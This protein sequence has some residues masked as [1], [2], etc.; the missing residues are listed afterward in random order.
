MKSVYYCYAEQDEVLC[1]ELERHLAILRRENLILEWH[2]RKIKP[3]SVYS[4]E[5]S[6]FLENADIFLLLYSADLFA[7]DKVFEAELHRALERQ[8][9]GQAVVIP[10]LIRQVSL[11]QEF[12]ASVQLP[13]NGVPVTSWENRDEAWSNVARGIRRTIT[14]IPAEIGPSSERRETS[15]ARIRIEY[16]ATFHSEDSALSETDLLGTCRPFI[17]LAWEERAP[18]QVRDVQRK[19]SP[20]RER[21]WA[22]LPWR[23]NQR[24]GHAAKTLAAV[25]LRSVEGKLSAGAALPW[26][27][28]CGPGGG[29]TTT[30][31]RALAEVAQKANQ[32]GTGNVIPVYVRLA[33]ISAA[34]S[35]QLT[36]M[37]ASAASLSQIVHTFAR[38]AERLRS[39]VEQD[40]TARLAVMLDGLDEIPQVDIRRSV[41]EWIMEGAGKFCASNS[42]ALTCRT[43]DIPASLSSSHGL[44]WHRPGRPRVQHM[45]LLPP[46]ADW[47]D[48]WIQVRCAKD[49]K[50]WR[51]LA[52]QI[53]QLRHSVLDDPRL[54]RT[55]F[56]NSP[57]LFV[58]LLQWLISERARDPDWVPTFPNHN[59]VLTR[60]IIDYSIKEAALY[61]QGSGAEQ[62]LPID[63]DEWTNIRQVVGK[64]LSQLALGQLV[65]PSDGWDLSEE[66]VVA[67]LRERTEPL[68]EH[69]RDAARLLLDKSR[70][71]PRITD[72]TRLPRRAF[73]H[74]L[75]LENLAAQELAHLIEHAT[76]APANG[77]VIQRAVSVIWSARCIPTAVRLLGPATMPKQLFKGLMACMQRSELST[78]L[79]RLVPADARTILLETLIACPENDLIMLGRAHG[80]SLSSVLMESMQN[81]RD[82]VS[83]DDLSRTLLIIEGAFQADQEMRAYVIRQRWEDIY[84]KD[85]KKFATWLRKNS[86]NTQF[87]QSLAKIW[88]LILNF[89]PSSD[90]PFDAYLSITFKCPTNGRDWPIYASNAESRVSLQKIENE[91]FKH[92][93]MTTAAIRS[94][95]SSLILWIV[96]H[97][98]FFLLAAGAIFLKEKYD[99]QPSM[100]VFDQ[101]PVPHGTGSLLLTI[102]VGTGLSV[103]P[104]VLITGM[105]GLPLRWARRRWQKLQLKVS[106]EKVWAAATDETINQADAMTWID[107]FS[108][109]PLTDQKE[110]LRRLEFLS[111]AHAEAKKRDANF[112][113]IAQLLDA[114][115]SIR[116]QFQSMR[117]QQLQGYRG[118]LTIENE[119][120]SLIDAGPGLR[121]TFRRDEFRI[122]H[123]DAASLIV[124]GG[125]G[126]GIYGHYQH[127][128]RAGLYGLI[129]GFLMLFLMG[130]RQIICS[131]RERDH[132]LSWSFWFLIIFLYATFNFGILTAALHNTEQFAMSPGNLRTDL[133]GLAIAR[134][135]LLFYDGLLVLVPFMFIITAGR[136]MLNHLLLELPRDKILKKHGRHFLMSLA[137]SSIVTLLVGTGVYV[138]GVG[139]RP[140]PY[141]ILSAHHQGIV[142]GQSTEMIIGS[143]LPV[144]QL[145]TL[146]VTSQRTPQSAQHTQGIHRALDSYLDALCQRSIWDWSA[147]RNGL[148]VEN[149]RVSFAELLG[150]L[151]RDRLL[152]KN[153]YALLACIY[154]AE[155]LTSL[156][157]QLAH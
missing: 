3:G 121:E 42:L 24:H 107:T 73:A 51:W 112:E 83:S 52:E 63:A 143:V 13:D 145:E 72:G 96:G 135:R 115:D 139:G 61:V 148:S 60:L 81:Q 2:K 15:M 43:L 65:D 56:F 110:V 16:L 70:L 10:I 71:L 87:A 141:P 68:S 28:H 31:V 53:R 4:T 132:R 157:P 125:A 22:M 41:L 34:A 75:I 140:N 152:T 155:F 45:Y 9:S 48:C 120:E 23:T 77:E 106:K 118:A 93:R 103:L 156:Q 116:K 29:K 101:F 26:I 67:T 111:R 69:A 74:P 88:E 123:I 151:D 50:T 114:A 130:G 82:S 79:N 104:I 105:L 142:E 19:P 38:D 138:A 78:D 57:F 84:L 86:Y 36:Q 18:E 30:V 94:S 32:Q 80:Y 14:S 59:D 91:Y 40:D 25:L 137:L 109:Q 55:S 117:Q 62:P 5:L 85:F 108:S 66:G 100:S 122:S 44:F 146:L 76:D 119:P 39:L 37:S 1:Q 64:T 134:M 99:R 133:P 127:I 8:R 11:N 20:A 129:P 46:N 113:I 153:H 92:K 27:I 17:D 98:M 90:N 54:T 128:Q 97:A 7:D 47:Q 12:A 21:V 6:N 150:L 95:L 35:T 154:E 144:L 126:A 89:Y 131:L 124:M 147:T 102:V 149:D 49:N 33:G 136:T 58:G